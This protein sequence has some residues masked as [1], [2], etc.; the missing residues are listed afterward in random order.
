MGSPQPSSSGVSSSPALSRSHRLI[1]V[2][3]NWVTA[4]RTW[5]LWTLL[6]LVSPAWILWPLLHPSKSSYLVHND[7]SLPDQLNIVLWMSL[8]A[9]IMGCG[10]FLWIFRSRKRKTIHQAASQLNAML[11]WM[12]GFALFP[13]L[14]LE[15]IEKK[16][17][18]FTFAIILLITGFA[19]RSFLAFALLAK[20]TISARPGAWRR[21]LPLSLLVLAIL[22]YAWVFSTLSISHYRGFRTNSHDLSIY[23]NIL[24]QSLQGN[25]L[26]CS[27]IRSGTHLSAHAD[28]ILFLISP[29][30]ALS[31]RPETLLI[32]QAVW[33]SLGALP[34]YFLSSQAFDRRWT[35]LALGLAYL[36]QPALHGLNLYVF[37]SL[38]LAGPLILWVIYALECKRNRLYWFF[39][40]L[41]LLTR[42]DMSLVACFI[43]LYGLFT[44]KTGR[45]M[46]TIAIACTYLAVV[47]VFFM[48]N[49]GLFMAKQPGNY[50]YDG[51]Y[52][53]MIP[54]ASTGVRGL[55]LSL[56]SNPQF[57][58]KLMTSEVKI[59]FL[60]KMILPVL[61]L[62]LFAGRRTIVLGYGAIFLFLA[63][64][65][66]VYSIQFQYSTVFFPFLL[67]LTPFG[68]ESI[69][70]RVKN[71]SRY[72]TQ[73]IWYAASLAIVLCSALFSSQYG[74]FQ[75]K[76][77]HVYFFDTSTIEQERFDWLQKTIDKHIPA[78]AS[79]TATPRPASIISNRHHAYYYPSHIDDADFV[80]IYRQDFKRKKKRKHTKI[81]NKRLRSQELELVDQF[82]DLQLYRRIKAK[83]D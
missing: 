67:A 53:A 20:K 76:K 57:S 13:L 33:L 83:S 78:D 16:S 32:F 24:W 73:Q 58:L 30:Y 74:A 43:G 51:Y 14:Q 47:K 68:I 12:L 72:S 69:S 79:V 25:L 61:L 11:M 1:L 48:T 62:P 81:L 80:L 7:L 21:L 27:F 35:G 4:L 82:N 45:G 55:L 54:H 71:G 46:L 49:P 75:F 6:L 65:Y 42:E 19:A 59:I 64:R 5:G 34:L 3:E 29:F 44:G 36:L 28:P 22:L 26:T 41:L 40:A 39:L 37:H 31:A 10:Y 17:P 8:S 38:A 50:A 9:L 23:A 18:F 77:D 56:S 63:S 2:I 15:G 52:K 60:A 66:A 70:K